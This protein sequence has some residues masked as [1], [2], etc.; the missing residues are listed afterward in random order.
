MLLM[1]LLELLIIVII[2][3]SNSFRIVINYDEPRFIIIPSQ[4]KKWKYQL[5]TCLKLN[6][7]SII[8]IYHIH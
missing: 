3:N 6:N 5:Y 2:N 1:Q 8:Y 4:T 7:N